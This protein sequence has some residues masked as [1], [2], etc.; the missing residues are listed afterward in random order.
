MIVLLLLKIVMYICT[1]Q[2]E[3]DM[4]ITKKVPLH[5]ILNKVR[6]NLISAF[7]ISLVV[8]FVTTKYKSIIP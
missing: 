4:L 2:I 5:Y 1:E 3:K 7:V 6:F 8:H